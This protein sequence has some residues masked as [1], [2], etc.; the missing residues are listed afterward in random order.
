MK[1]DFALDY[2][3]LTVERP[4]KLYLMARLV[5]SGT[6]NT[7]SRRPLNISLVLDRS[8]SMAGNKLDYT[9]QAAQF[10]VQHLSASDTLSVVLYNEQVTT[11]IPPAQ[12]SH[13]DAI[14]QRL[15]QIKASGMTN[16]SGGWLEGCKWVEDGFS[17][18]SLNRVILMTD[19]LANRGVTNADQL[20]ALAR[21]KRQANII[22]TTMGLGTDFNEDLLI[23]MADAGGGAFYFIESP[24]VAP[25]IFKEEL[26]DLLNV[27][28]QNL[29]VSV[30]MTAHI[31]TVNQLNAYN[32]HTDGRRVTFSMGDI[33][34]NEV[35]T[36]LLE[37]SIPALSELGECE[38]ARLHFEYD[39]I[40]NDGSQHQVLDMPIVVNVTQE[41]ADDK[42]NQEVRRSVLLLQAAR[43]RRDAVAA[44]DKGEYDRASQILKLAAN[45]IEDSQILHKE[46]VEEHE[47]LLQQATE[48]QR[49]DEFYDS[50]SRKMMATQ[51]IYTM[52]DRH[53]ST[54]S[55]RSREVERLLR[56]PQEEQ[57]PGVTPIAIT[58]REQTMPL[59]GELIRMGRAPQNE[60]ILEAKNVSRFHCQIKRENDRLVIEDLGSTNGTYVNEVRISEPHMLSVGD[61]V[62]VGHEQIIFHDHD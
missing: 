12:V 36:L 4:Q 14:N 51:A 41:E 52:T 45:A 49:G 56:S 1:A 17:S 29:T 22:T 62:R 43:A 8:G 40:N 32:M 5:S 18:E 15:N 50:R 34:G 46:L 31:S 19:G 55:L 24:E 60:I 6:L 7:H 37:L 21:Q 27:V 42:G 58:W 26:R 13:K 16:L 53:E 30:E 10:L 25:T 54:Q 59:N 38:I 33:Y 3:V 61:I 28:G 39:E 2:D 35:K 57:K 44:A 20:V 48:M 9:R 47:V 23:A 11:L